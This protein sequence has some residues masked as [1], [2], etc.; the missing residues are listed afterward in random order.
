MQSKSFGKITKITG[1]KVMILVQYS[2]AVNKVS[3]DNFVLNYVSIGALLGTKLVD[4]R[5]LVLTVEEIYEHDMEHFISAS[6]SGIY[7]NVLQN[8][9]LEQ[10]RI[11]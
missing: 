9:R 6:I 2:E 3:V 5:T 11:R 7:D 10:T 4:G 8:L 1:S